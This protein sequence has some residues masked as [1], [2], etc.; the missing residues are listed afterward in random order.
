MRSIFLLL[1][2]ACA[3]VPR[4]EPP[5]V[6]R[7]PVVKVLFTARRGGAVR[8]ARGSGFVVDG[9][10]HVVTG[11]HVVDARGWPDTS[12]RVVIDGETS[13]AARVVAFDSGGDLALLRLHP[14]PRGPAPLRLAADP[15]RPGRPVRVQGYPGGGAFVER[16]G[17]IEVLLPADRTGV[18][19]ARLKGAIEVA[20]GNSGGPVLDEHGAVLGVVVEKNGAHAY[21]VPSDYLRRRF[22]QWSVKTP[23]VPPER[24]EAWE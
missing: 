5:V 13:Y 22:T 21:A 9:A 10:G 12:T 19:K 3:A 8:F 14:V 18:R 16:T 1:L 2:G 11:H 4:P 17:T 6:H 24:G 20:Q 23:H 15:I 7:N